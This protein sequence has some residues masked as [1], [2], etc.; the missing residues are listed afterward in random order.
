MLCMSGMPGAYL[1]PAYTH[2]VLIFNGTNNFFNNSAN[3]G[4]AIY[5]VT[6]ISLIF[7]GISNFSHNSA[8]YEGGAVVT[9][10]D[11]VLRFSGTNNFNNS[12]NNGGA[13]FAAV[14]TSLSF[15]GTSNL[16]SNSA[17]QGGAISANSNSKLT[18]NGNINFTNNGQNIRDSR[19]G[20]MHLAIYST[21]LVFPNTTV[22]WE[23][24]YAT[25]G[26]AIYVLTTIPFTQWKMTQIATFI[27]TTKDCFFQLPGQ[28]LSNGFDVQLVF[29]NNSAYNA[30]SVLYGGTIDNCCLDSM[31][32]NSGKVFDNIVRY[33]DDNTTSSIL[34]TH[35][36][37]AHVKTIIQTAVSQ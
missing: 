3:S 30:G 6:N 23:N 11:G 17:M 5:A 19:G 24:N 10:G 22:C 8:G 32:Y 2:A 36:V 13:I 35:F 27:A 29:K 9:A 12:A 21:F 31:T 26:G 28:N 37:C 15:T 18:F 4:G 1:K 16:S 20:A 14:H 25:L 33:K 34:L 7:V